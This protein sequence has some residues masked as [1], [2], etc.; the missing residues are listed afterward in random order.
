MTDIGNGPNFMVKIIAESSGVKVPTFFGFLV[1]YS[2]PIL[3]P[4]LVLIAWLFI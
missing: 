3:L 4:I 1:K 2:L